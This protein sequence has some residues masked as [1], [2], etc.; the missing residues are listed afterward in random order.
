MFT[1]SF[2]AGVMCRFLTRLAGR[3]AH[4]IRLVVHRHSAHRS[5]TVRAWLDEHADRVEPHFLPSCSPELS[6]DELVNADLERSLPRHHRARDQAQLTVETRRFLPSAMP[7]PTSS[8]ATSTARTSA[9]RS[10]GIL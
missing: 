1:E 8:A 10:N 3:F 9:K 6:P 4:E 2:D 7:A 5:E